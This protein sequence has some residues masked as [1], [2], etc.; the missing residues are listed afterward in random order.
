MIEKENK[1]L[2]DD[3]GKSLRTIRKT[4]RLTMGQLAELS[5]VSAITISN[6]ENG[7]SNPTIHVLWKLSKALDVTLTK[8]IGFSNNISEASGQSMTR[9]ISN[10][11]TGWQVQPVFQDDNMEVY[12]VCL[13][14]ESINREAEQSKET[15]EI[16]T[17]MKGHV[18][19]EVGSRQYEVGEYETIHFDSGLPHTYINSSSEDVLMNIV[20]KYKNI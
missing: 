16:L 3:I 5:D 8:L 2:V 14:K 10:L 12:R 7:R 1:E 18:T 9:P 13:K 17:V 19:L 20:I 4:R 11:D 15:M 6:I